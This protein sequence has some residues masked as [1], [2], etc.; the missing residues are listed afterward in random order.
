MKFLTV[1]AGFALLA[2]GLHAQTAP[3]KPVTPAKPTPPGVTAPAKP[4]AKEEEPKILGTVI[5][6][7][8][9][10]FL[11]LTLQDGKF[12]LTF[13]DKKKKPMAV[14]VTRALARWPNIHGPGDNRTVMNPSETTA[15]LGS[16]FVRGPYTFKVY[17][18]LLKGEGEDAVTETYTIDFRA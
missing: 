3:A 16:Q 9:G 2:N 13:Y 10:T 8:N 12:K 18:T 15:L 11:G 17:L 6:R 1:L 4:A 14:D 5:N 7:P